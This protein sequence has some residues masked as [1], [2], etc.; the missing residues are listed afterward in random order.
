MKKHGIIYK[1]TSPSGKVY[2]GQTTQPMLK[3]RSRHYSDAYNGKISKLCSAI[4]KYGDRIVWETVQDNITID[5]L[6]KAEIFYI[7]KYNSYNNGYNMTIGGQN[8][9]LTKTAKKK[10]SKF[11]KGRRHSERTKRKMS[12]THKGMHVG[13]KNNMYGK[14]LSKEHKD[15]ISKSN[16]KKKTEAHS[17]NIARGKGAIEFEV[18]RKNISLGIWNNYSKCARDLGLSYRSVARH[19]VKHKS[20]HKGYVFVVLERKE[21]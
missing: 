16:S 15:A 17:A 9:Q 4:R 6:D 18:F 11:N 21:D 20:P 14:K 12:E 1:A 13:S 2:I 10:I 8:P 5:K 3:R 7:D 19:A